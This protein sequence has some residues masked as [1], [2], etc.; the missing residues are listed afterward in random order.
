MAN[1]LVITRRVTF[2]ADF[3]VLLNAA[4]LNAA[5]KI[6]TFR[7]SVFKENRFKDIFS[8][9]L[10]AVPNAFDTKFV[11]SGATWRLK[12]AD[13]DTAKIRQDESVGTWWLT[14]DTSGDVD[15]IA[16]GTFKAVNP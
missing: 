10:D 6:V 9:I 12:I 15:E 2:N 13:E 7:L 1:E 3:D 11:T 16:S 8:V 14:V 4:P 5:G